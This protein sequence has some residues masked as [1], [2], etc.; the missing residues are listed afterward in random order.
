MG[1]FDGLQGYKPEKITDGFAP[2]KFKGSCLVNYCRIED[3]QGE[4]P[5]FEGHKFL[6]Y[7]LEVAQGQDNQGRRLWKSYNLNSQDQDAKGKTPVQK[8]ADLMFT[9]GMEFETEEQLQECCDKMVGMTLEVNAYYTEKF[10]NEDGDA[11]QLH[12]IIGE[13]KT[14]AEKAPSTVPF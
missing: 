2:F 8:L 14:K 5:E 12:R 10:K 7:E 3:Y 1:L 4:K 11:I 9:L 13:A 6:R